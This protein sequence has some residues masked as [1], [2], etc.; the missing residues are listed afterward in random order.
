MKRI[1]KLRAL[2]LA[3]LIQS[4]ALPVTAAPA[5][6]PL[7]PG[8]NHVTTV[9]GISEYGLPNGLRVLL[10]PDES[11][12]NVTVNITYLVGSR[13]ENYGETGMAHLLEHMLFKGSKDHPDI[14]KELSERG[15]HSNAT[16]DLDRT[17]YFE[18][19]EATEPNLDWA[20][21]MEADRMVSSFI[22][23]KD[24][25]KEMTVVR[26]EFESRENN[27]TEVMIER[28]QEIAYIWHN[29]GHPTIGA[30]SDIENVPIDHL[31][32]FYRTY[33]QP[34]NAVLVVA[35]RFDA[36]TTLAKIAQIFGTIPRPTRT[37]PRLY[38]QEPTQDGERSVTLRRMGGVQ[39]VCVMYHVPSGAHSDFAPLDVLIT[40]MADAP[41]GR[42]YKALVE[43]KKAITVAG[44]TFQ[45]HDPGMAM[46][47]AEVQQGTA[48]EPARDTLVDIAE[49]ELARR[50]LKP[51][52]VERAKNVLLKHL[53]LTL[54]NS[55]KIGLEL[56]EWEAMGDW[57]LL[58]LY[59]DQVKKVTPAD[60]GR[61]AATY[62]KQSNRT[63]AMFVPTQ[64]PDRAEIPQSPNV[65][66]LVTEYRGQEEVAAGERFEA[67]PQNIEKRLARLDVRGG[68]K[69]SMLQKKTRGGVVHLD[70]ELHIGDERSLRG[71]AMVGAITGATLLRGTAHHTRQQLKDEFD[72]LKAQV[73]VAGTATDV[74]VSIETMGQNLPACMN[75]VA[76]ILREPSFPQAEFEQI[77]QEHIASIEESKSDPRS[78]ATNALARHLAPYPHEDVR[79]VA[80]PE[81]EI[82]DIKA[83]RLDD[84]KAFHRVFYG[85]SAG[86]VAV[87][88]D[89]D[90]KSF[91]A[92]VGDLFGDWKNPSQFTR[93]PSLFHEVAAIDSALD[94]PDKEN[95]FYTGGIEIPMT[96]DDPDYP[97]M[98]L[99]TTM[100]GG[101]FLNSRL[102]TRLRQ[103]EGVS[104]GVRSYFSAQALDK[105]AEFG[106]YAIYAP[107]NGPKV[108]KAVREVLETA[109]KNGFTDTEVEIAKAGLLQSRQ[110]DRAKDTVL[111]SRLQAYRF[112]GRTMQWDIDFESKIR[113]LTGKQVVEALRRHIDLARLNVVMA[114]D[115]KK[116]ARGATG[117]N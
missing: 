81:E 79:Y 53:E 88:G 67:S 64:K 29:Y 37:L 9:E 31:Q 65:A 71:K 82:A 21:R 86:E 42:L 14:Y 89:F 108:K 80:T 13:M 44:L 66:S 101:G 69:L 12:E 10:F 57:R 38:T 27:P 51:E 96:S 107:Q 110:V 95:A 109:L 46:Y 87:V 47:T 20:L 112:I 78:L 23:K 105:V 91:P 84:I 22:S 70:M 32:A 117:N 100:L 93:V 60:V 114:G 102:A 77:C 49:N 103:Q 54:N 25:D 43:T 115:A 5:P 19:V 74:T 104:Y 52:E 99:A 83:I 36:S 113:A 59:R 94:T 68:L 62:F 50:P 28:A 7:P 39:N 56:S 97:A 3:I 16:T 61:V 63:L 58:F 73:G 106:I 17:N 40:A 75:L 116:A 26:N 48:L 76:E 30:R 8:V 45:Q 24:L 55:Q 34:D 2:I 92:L 90:E 15:A 18:T 41:A 35:G 33:Y 111:V 72:R 11:V 4:L 6:I 1:F 98:T 85:A